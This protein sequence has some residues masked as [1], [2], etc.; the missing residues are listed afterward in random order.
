VIL[1]QSGLERATMTGPRKSDELEATLRQHAAFWVREEVD[2]PLVGTGARRLHFPLRALRTLLNAEEGLITPDMME[3]GPFLDHIDE[4][5]SSE[6][7]LLGDL[8]WSAYPSAAIPWM[9]AILG[10]PIHISKESDS[11]WSEPF[12]THWEQ[13]ADIRLSP[14]NEWLSKLLNLTEALVENSK[15]RYP[16]SQTLMRG[17]S[18]MMVALRGAERLC[19]DF[20]DYPAEVG[21]LAEI[22]TDIWIEVNKM[23]LGIIPAFHDGYCSGLM[24][25]WAPGQ[26][27]VFQE[28]AS[29]FLSPSM[30]REFL[31][32]CDRR[33][34]EN[35]E[36]SMIHLHSA[37]L[38]VVDDLLDVDPLTAIQVAFDPSGPSLEQLM[39]VFAK[40]MERKPLLILGVMGDLA[41]G[42]IDRIAGSLPAAG[43]CLLIAE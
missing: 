30:Y 43:L 16:V 17:P 3:V 27:A 41:P 39:P 12:L 36:H 32:P 9:E 33:I 18:D 34:A 11:L 31:L 7:L 37:A 22:C 42:D 21:R 15:G 35:F 4:Q 14:E 23:V 1:G 28:D 38:H 13:M 5:F 8:F 19:L 20:Y 26:A 25:V 10:C 24:Q 29:I 6:G 2:R 40:I